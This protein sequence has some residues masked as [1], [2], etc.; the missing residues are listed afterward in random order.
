MRAWKLITASGSPASHKVRALLRWA[1]LPVRESV[2]SALVLKSEVRPRLGG[3]RVPML[4]SPSNEALSD[5]RLIAAWLDAHEPGPDLTPSSA[6]LRFAMRLIEAFGDEILAPAAVSLRWNRSP[7]QA[8]AELGAS[9][10]PDLEPAR[11]ARYARLLGAQLQTSLERRGFGQAGIERARTLTGDVLDAL[12]AH[13][14]SH[15]FLF[16]DQPSLADFS[17]YG[18]LGLLRPERD[19]ADLFERHPAVLRW[20]AECHAPFER[21]EPGFHDSE[22]MAESLISIASLA[23]E[24]FLPEALETCAVLGEWAECHPGRM[25]PPAR[26]RR[27]ANSG[28]VELRPETQWV[29]QRVLEPLHQDLPPGQAKA[30]ETLL[31]DIGFEKLS[32]FT[33]SRIVVQDHHSFSLDMKAIAPSPQERESSE[34]VARALIKAREDAGATR[35]LDRMII[36]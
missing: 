31:R 13:F 1:N 7:E 15:A 16:G 35:H 8:S 17:L 34:A 32:D 20:L 29:L 4:I 26:L 25:N 14:S 11:R 28:A 9:I 18:A 30:L 2:A 12:H 3:V 19:G 27:D 36:S 24:S 5:T 22:A 21:R 33:P 10:Y 6:Q 23:A